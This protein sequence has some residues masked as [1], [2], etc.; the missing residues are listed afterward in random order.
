MNLNYTNTNFKKVSDI[1]IPDIFYRR[2]K[3]GISVMDDLFGE[4]ILP[5]S[6][7]TMCAAAGCGK[8]T[9]LLQ[10]L[11]GLSKNSY[12]V[13]YSS[14]EENTYQLAFT[15]NRIGV[16]RV[17]VANM[18]DIDELV[19]AMDDLDALVV[20]SFQ[21][22]TTKK[23]MNSRALEKYAVSKLTRAAKDKECTI[24]FIMHLTKDGK[25]K[26][27]TIVPHTVDVNMNIEIDGDIDDDAR[28]IFFTKNRFGP[29]NE[30]T[31]F[32]GRKG[33][34]F[35]APVVV[36]ESDNKAPNKKTRKRQELDAI[37]NMKEPPILNAYRVADNLN[38][39]ITRAQY[40][41]RELTVNGKLNKFGRGKDAS[42][43]H[44]KVDN[45]DGSV[46]GL[47]NQKQSMALF[48]KVS[49]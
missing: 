43:K 2:Y 44:V 9:L 14:G 24:F 47:L 11:E 30:L 25:L 1:K 46:L 31:L 10:L 38:I 37:L 26:G 34:D 28:K 22:L 48:E 19:D 32:I 42:Y 41:L 40:L 12:N 6:S 39:D 5:G 21:A 3:S 27:G 45:N 13:G 4:G 8:T 23:K 49:S 35:S 18:T 36:E 20:D 15:C 33:Y 7:I 17:A 29:L 16:K